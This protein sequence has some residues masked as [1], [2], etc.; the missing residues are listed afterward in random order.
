MRLIIRI[1]LLALLLF[2]PMAASLHAA[3]NDQVSVRAILVS[4][5]AASSASRA[6]NNSGVV[7]AAPPCPAKDPSRSARASPCN[8]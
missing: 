2:A 4:A 8:L 7:E 5:C 1:P 6:S 3:S